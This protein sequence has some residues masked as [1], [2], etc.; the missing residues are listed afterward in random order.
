[1]CVLLVH[2]DTLDHC[3][4]SFYRILINLF[5]PLSEKGKG[6]SDHVQVQRHLLNGLCDPADALREE[7]QG[8]WGGQ[9]SQE[10]PQRL[11][12]VIGRL[13][14]PDLEEKWAQYSDKMLLKVRSCLTAFS[15]STW[16]YLHEK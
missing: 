8:F 11:V 5:L 12:E 16:L 6:M 13:Y 9:L 1:M 2:K 14:E 15:G 3:R 7:V 4:L 10:M